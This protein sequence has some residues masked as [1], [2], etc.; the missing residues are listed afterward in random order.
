MQNANRRRGAPTPRPDTA[1]NI[2]NAAE[3]LVQTR[4]YNGFSYADIAAQLGV[5]KASLHYHFASKAD[6]G[7]ALI[8]RYHTAFTKALAGIDDAVAQPRRKLAGYVGLYDA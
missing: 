3:R 8:E 6:L 1:Q 2:L 4:G 5:T 7:C